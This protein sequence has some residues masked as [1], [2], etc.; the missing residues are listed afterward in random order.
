MP[1]KGHSGGSMG[2]VEKSPARASRE[3]ASRRREEKALAAKSGPV[4]TVYACI[5]A[6]DPD[7][8]KANT[9]QERP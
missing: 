7:A 3:R 1:H 5:C 2:A 6:R 9:H 4:T 8:C